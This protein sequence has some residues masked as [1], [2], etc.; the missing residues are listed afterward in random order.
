M[1]V[2]HVEQKFKEVVVKKSLNKERRKTRK[3][4]A[5]TGFQPGCLN[6]RRQNYWKNL[7]SQRNARWTGVVSSVVTRGAPL[8][9]RRSQAS[10]LHIH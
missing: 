6:G 9:L 5:Q 3:S 10:V 4:K 7:V 8:S 2:L 1:L